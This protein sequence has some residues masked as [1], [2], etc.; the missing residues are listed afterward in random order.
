M[1]EAGRVIGGTSRGVR[2]EG[3]RSTA[4]RPLTDRVKESL[5]G[6]LEAYRSIEANSPGALLVTVEPGRPAIVREVTVR[7]ARAL[8]TVRGTLDRLE[9]MADGL[10]DTWLR[11]VVEERPGPG[12][13][14]TVREILPN[15]LHVDI[16]ERFR[17]VRARPGGNG[18]GRAARGPRELFRDFL[19][20]A[21]RPDGEVAALFDRLY[22][23]V[24]S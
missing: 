12:L 11:V 20:D 7:S 5:F 6:A 24:T 22:D 9:A 13:A 10:G 2:L 8:A 14:E 15:A 21:N 18:E 3:P 19:K 4:T 23:E 16:D 17:P 1:P